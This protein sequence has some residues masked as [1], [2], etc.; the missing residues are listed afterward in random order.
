MEVWALRS[1]ACDIGIAYGPPQVPRCTRRCLRGYLNHKVL[2]YSTPVPRRFR[3]GA[4]AERAYWAVNINKVRTPPAPFLRECVKIMPDFSKPGDDGALPDSFPPWRWIVSYTVHPEL[5][6]PVKYAQEYRIAVSVLRKIVSTQEPRYAG[7][8][9][10]AATIANARVARLKC[11]DPDVI[12]YTR[13]L[14]QGWFTHINTSL[15]RAFVTIG[16][17]YLKKGDT[18]PQGQPSPTGERF[19]APGGMTPESYTL[20]SAEVNKRVHEIYSEADVRDL[21]VP[22]ANVFTV[23]YGEYVPSVGSADYKPLVERAQDLA[24]FHFSILNERSQADSGLEIVRREWFC[25]TNPDIA[26][27]HL[28]IQT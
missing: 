22:D 24:Q 13:I 2:I 25:A 16:A 18:P 10:R 19:A 23:S 26:V 5:L 4:M 8:Y 20:P 12:L 27:V 9:D 14:T 28:Y 3:P 6:S 17:V 7:L 15:G 1:R 11:A 21:A